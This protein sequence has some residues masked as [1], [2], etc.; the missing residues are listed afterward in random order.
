MLSQLSVLPEL[1]AQILEVQK[2]DVNLLKMLEKP[3]FYRGSNGAILFKGRLC[4][5]EDVALKERVMAEAHKS[6]F[7]IHP[8]STKMYKD[9]RRSYWWNGMKK[10]IT[11]YVLRCL[12]CQQIKIE[13]QKRRGHMQAI[14][15]P[16]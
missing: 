8:G 15:L 7:S 14:E 2:S 1:H 3:D 10:N 12:T 11:E 5:L 9:M 6:K 16:E 13:H 4:I